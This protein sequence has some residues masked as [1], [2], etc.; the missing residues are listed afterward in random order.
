MLFLVSTLTKKV[1][2]ISLFSYSTLL[3]ASIVLLPCLGINWV[4]GF[5]VVLSDDPL[6]REIVE[7]I[8]L[9]FVTLQ[10][11]AIFLVHCVLNT[12]VFE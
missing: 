4:L 8:V 5:L 1:A 2:N 3:Q 6:Y 10:G 11:L 9:V 12:E 7:Y